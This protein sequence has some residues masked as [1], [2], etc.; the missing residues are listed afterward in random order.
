MA[1]ASVIFPAFGCK[2]LENHPDASLNAEGLPIAYL[3]SDIKLKYSD[4][5]LI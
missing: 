3:Y 5:S 1:I 2:Y 4:I